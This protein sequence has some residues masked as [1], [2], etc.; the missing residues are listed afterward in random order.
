MAFP[1]DYSLKVYGKEG[2]Q[3]VYAR[4]LPNFDYGIMKT[5]SADRTFVLVNSDIKLAN[6]ILKD[7]IASRSESEL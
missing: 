4:A 2:R 1:R 5:T 6:K 7:L 3:K